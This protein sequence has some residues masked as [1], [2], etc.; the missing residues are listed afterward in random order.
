MSPKF[1]PRSA[2]DLTGGIVYFGRMLDKIRLHAADRLR[3]DF[4]ANLGVGFDGRCSRFLG[5]SYE[6][7]RERVLAGGS[8]DEI[9]AWCFANGWH[10]NDEQVLVW[11]KFMLKRGWRDEEDGSTQELEAYKTASGL[12]HRTDIITFFDFYEVDEG[13]KL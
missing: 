6:A 13:R 12:A 4:H 5:V 7:L 9:L 10:P 11:N 3:E 1:A 2:Y 8:D